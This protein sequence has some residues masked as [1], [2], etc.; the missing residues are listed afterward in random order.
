MI[1]YD[2]NLLIKSDK[3]IVPLTLY[4][5]YEFRPDPKTLKKFRKKIL[6]KTNTNKKELDFP[7]KLYISRGDSSKARGIKN[8]ASLEKKLEQH[9]FFILKSSNFSVKEQIQFFKNADIIV[10]AH[11]AGLSNIAF[12]K[13]TCKI[14]E[15]NQGNY[16]NNCFS[17]VYSALELQGTYIHY[18]A[19][20]SESV[21]VKAGSYHEQKTMVNTNKLLEILMTNSI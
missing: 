5:P 14:I 11:G 21:N 6:K 13:R 17:A 9:N 18:I 3:L 8:E 4:N 2:K 1:H 19:P 7:K 20:S 16:F 10:G 15:I 12:A